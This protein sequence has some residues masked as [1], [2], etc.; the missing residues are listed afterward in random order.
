MPDERWLML[1]LEAPLVAFGGVAIDQLGLTRDFP[2]QSMLTGLFANAFGWTRTDWRAHQ[3]LQDRLVFAA[4]IDRERA[5]GLLT[6]TQNAKL[7][8]N[9]RGWTTWGVPEGRDGASYSAPHRR[10][11]DYHTDAH[12]VVALRLAPSD[13]GPDLEALAAALDRPARPLFIGRKPCLPSGP[14]LPAEADGRFVTAPDAHTALARRVLREADAKDA[15]P[16]R[17]RAL[18][19]LGEGP[20]TTGNLVNR[21]VDLPDLRNWRTGL[22]GGVRK[23]VEGFVIPEG[24]VS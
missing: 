24:M 3:D 18:W 7:E 13:A 19:P 22:H 15:S 10:W 12:V 14:L 2:A 8:K 20:E 23:V 11:R 17:L 6:D 1:D 5:A 16:P 4:R 21:V 9:D